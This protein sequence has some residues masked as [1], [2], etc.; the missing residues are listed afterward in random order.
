ME[1]FRVE[2]LVSLA[3]NEW[4]QRGSVEASGPEAG[5]DAV[6]QVAEEAG[7]YRVRPADDDAAQPALYRVGPGGSVV[8]VDAI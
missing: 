6:R 3:D 7:S 8:R 4:K 2:Q 5:A 1:R